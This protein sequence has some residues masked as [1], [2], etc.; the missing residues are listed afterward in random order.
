MA[1]QLKR[2]QASSLMRFRDHSDTPH[3]VR[4]LWTSDQPVAEA[5]TRQHTTLTRNI[6]TPGG[7]RTHD[8]SKRA[9]AEP[10]FSPRGQ[11]EWP[12]NRLVNAITAIRYQ[13]RGERWTRE[14]LIVTCGPEGGGDIRMERSFTFCAHQRS[15]PSLSHQGGEES[16]VYSDTSANEWPC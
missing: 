15:I 7:I 12:I 10:Q 13:V 11:C 16:T 3:S 6:Q 8:S 2:A 14:L 1:R 5:A 9:E 4:L